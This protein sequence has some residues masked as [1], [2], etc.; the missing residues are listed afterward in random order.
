MH[1]V[2]NAGSVCVTSLESPTRF[3]DIVRIGLP[4]TGIESILRRQ[5]YRQVN[6]D[7]EP[8]R[9]AGTRERNINRADQMLLR[10]TATSLLRSR[11]RAYPTI[12]VDLLHQRCGASV[13][14]DSMQDVYRIL[15]LFF[16]PK[17]TYDR[18]EY[19]ITFSCKIRREV[20]RDFLR[21]K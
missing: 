5:R 14:I 16:C 20:D 19:F 13:K 17:R 18:Y 12:V 3:I 7:C 4:R 9:D 2:A 10:N 6:P 21:K 11:C 15:Y 8:R 1:I